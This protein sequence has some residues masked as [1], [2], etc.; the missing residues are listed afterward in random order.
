MGRTSVLLVDDNP[1]FL[2]QTSA[3]LLRESDIEVVGSAASGAEAVALVERLK[4]RVELMDVA[5]PGMDG[6]EATRRLKRLPNP[7]VVLVL[8]LHGD[9]AYRAAAGAEGFLCKSDLAAELLPC[10]RRFCHETAGSFGTEPGQG[11]Q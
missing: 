9:P 3:W 6:L 7:P 10:L 1:L 11:S 4:P 8:T 5:M 2:E